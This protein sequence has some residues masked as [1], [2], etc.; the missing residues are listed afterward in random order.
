MKK[1]KLFPTPHVELRVHVSDEMIADMKEC[2]HL[3]DPD[4]AK[5]SWN[6]VEI[7]GTGL[8]EYSEVQRQVLEDEDEQIN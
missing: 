7:E 5:C 3:I 1:I 2:R 8:C 6:N 4:C